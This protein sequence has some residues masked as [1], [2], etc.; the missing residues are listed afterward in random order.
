M[1]RCFDF[2]EVVIHDSSGQCPRYVGG[3]CHP[4]VVPD[5]PV[6]DEQRHAIEA[7]E[8]FLQGTLGPVLRVPS[9]GV[10]IDPVTGEDVDHPQVR[11]VL[12]KISPE[13]PEGPVH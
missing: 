12:V 11:M 4:E 5:P 8:A 3:E 9:K 6:D 1:T 10:T 2:P 7:H 13:P